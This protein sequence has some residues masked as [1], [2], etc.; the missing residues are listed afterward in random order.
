MIPTVPHSTNC[1]SKSFSLRYS[2]GSF[3]GLI[4]ADE[5][6]FWKKVYLFGRKITIYTFQSDLEYNFT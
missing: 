1:H 3:T 4:Q 2:S 5:V 6:R